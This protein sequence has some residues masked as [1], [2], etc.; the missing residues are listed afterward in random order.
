MGTATLPDGR[1]CKV[2]EDQG[3][4]SYVRSP[5]TSGLRR[6]T[7]LRATANLTYFCTD[8]HPSG[9]T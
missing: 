5:D 4:P 9:K 7:L 6:S 2:R 1:N 8:G 3:L